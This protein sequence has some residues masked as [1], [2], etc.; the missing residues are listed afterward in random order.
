VSPILVRL[1]EWQS[2][3]PEPG[4]P[5][6][7]LDL[8]GE[9]ATR[10]LARRLSEA[11][12]LEVT[13][14]R[15]GLSIRAFSHVGRVRLGP[16]EV[17]VAPKLP[18]PSLLRLLRYAYGLRDLRLLSDTTHEVEEM[19]F[20]DLLVWQLVEEARELLSRGLRRNYVRKADDLTSP[21]GRIDLHAV[22]RRGG[23]SAA[24]LPC[25]HYQR[26]EDTPINQALLAGLRLGARLAS[27]RRLRFRALRLA[28]VMGEFV[29]T[30]R[31]ERDV[32][33]RLRGG[34][35]RMARAYEPA[36]TIIEI[37][38]EARGTSLE[39]DGAGAE[40]PGFLFDMNQFFQ[41]LLARFLGENLEGYRFREEF[42]LKGM[43]AYVP[44]HNPR[45]RQAPTPRPDFVLMSG[46]QPVAILDAK[47]RDLWERPLPREM[48]YQLAIYAMIHEG[49]TS[50]ILYPTPHAEAT[51]ARIEVRDPLRG[52][53]RALVVV[54][55]VDVGFLERLVSSKASSTVLR[56]RRQ[57]AYQLV[58]GREGERRC[59][60]ELPAAAATE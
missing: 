46:S 42:G 28:E 22:A 49:G 45:R 37:L 15:A 11:N 36:V 48:L 17:I 19:G 18:V 39:G 54:R 10:A 25:V 60:G 7:G 33:R 58:F 41:A 32:L 47:Y 9:P 38:H 29:S 56:D 43:I 35:D 57:Y 14:L 13:E 44:G 4:G 31:L 50:T 24:S 20:H 27:D 16:V 12:V 6:V 26:D 51:E 8:S 30:I 59:P 53:R 40:L 55:P 52:G 2:L 21:R 3:F 5:L 1:S 34:M 23:I